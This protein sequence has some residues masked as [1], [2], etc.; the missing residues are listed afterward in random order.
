MA[1]VRIEV[2]PKARAGLPVKV[3]MMRLRAKTL[4]AVTLAHAVDASVFGEV[5]FADPLL[6]EGPDEGKLLLVPSS[7]AGVKLA[8]MKWCVRLLLASPTFPEAKF[9]AV[10]AEHE[11]VDWADSET[12]KA[13]LVHLPEWAWKPE[14]AKAIADTRA[15][16][17]AEQADEKAVEA[18]AS[19]GG[20]DFGDAPAGAAA[21]WR[22]ICRQC[23]ATGKPSAALTNKTLSMLAG[24]ARPAAV[25]AVAWLSSKRVVVVSRGGAVGEPDLFSPLVWAEEAAA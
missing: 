22:A 19:A 14:R 4:M 12:G 6:G 5:K 11:I 18:L 25:N 21:V 10:A 23:R 9:D 20:P 2:K 13:L 3:A 1:F 15:Q 7:G 16:I 24:V 17:E 8:R